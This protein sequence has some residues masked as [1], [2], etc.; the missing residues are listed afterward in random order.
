MTDASLLNVGVNEK[1]EEQLAPQNADDQFEEALLRSI[2][3]NDLFA[4]VANQQKNGSNTS[5]RPWR[6]PGLPGLPTMK[7]KL[8]EYRQMS[9]IDKLTTALKP[10]VGFDKIPIPAIK[11]GKLHG[12]TKELS[13][14]SEHIPKSMGH[15]IPDASDDEDA[16]GN[17]VEH[18]GEED[19]L[20]GEGQKGHKE[21]DLDDISD[22][23]LLQMP[24]DELAVLLAERDNVILTSGHQDEQKYLIEAKD[25][26]QRIEAKKNSTIST[27]YEAELEHLKQQLESTKQ[28]TEQIKTEKQAADDEAREAAEEVVR[29]HTLS[30]EAAAAKQQFGSPSKGKVKPPSTA[31][32]ADAER[33]AHGK[34]LQRIEAYKKLQAINDQE[35]KIRKEMREKEAKKQAE[36]AALQK[37]IEEKKTGVKTAI[38]QRKATEKKQKQAQHKAELKAIK[39]E[40]L[41]A[42]ADIGALEQRIEYA[43]NAKESLEE[44]TEDAAKIEEQIAEAH[45]ASNKD[46]ET[47][48]R[49][50]LLSYKFDMKQIVE[51]KE[52][53]PKLMSELKKLKE[54]E[55]NIDKKRNAELRAQD[56]TN[57]TRDIAGA[58]VPKETS[59][60]FHKFLK[61]TKDKKAATIA[62]QEDTLNGNLYGKNP[63][64]SE[65]KR[66]NDKYVEIL[67]RR[68]KSTKD[69]DKR[70]KLEQ[71]I[72]VV[73]DDPD[74]ETDGRP[75]THND[76][77]KQR[78]YITA[79]PS[80]FTNK[81]ANDYVAKN[82]LS[83][84]EVGDEIIDLLTHGVEK[85]VIDGKN[86]DGSKKY[87]T[88][89]HD[90]GVKGVDSAAV[91][92][93]PDGKFVGV[94]YEPH[95]GKA[96]TGKKI[97]VK[98]YAPFKLPKVSGSGKKGAYNTYT[99]GVQRDED[100]N[101]IADDAGNRVV[102]INKNDVPQLLNHLANVRAG[103]YDEAGNE[104]VADPDYIDR[105]KDATTGKRPDNIAQ[106][107]QKEKDTNAKKI[108]S[109][110]AI[111]QERLAEEKKKAAEKKKPDGEEALDEEKLKLYLSTESSQE[112]AD[113]ERLE[114]ILKQLKQL[115]QERIE[116]REKDEGAEELSKTEESAKL[117]EEY[118]KLFEKYHESK[119]N[120]TKAIDADLKKYDQSNPDLSEQFESIMKTKPKTI[121]GFF[122]ALD[123]IAKVDRRYAN[124]IRESTTASGRLHEITFPYYF[125][126]VSDTNDLPA[127]SKGSKGS[128]N[129][130]GSK[131]SKQF[132][133]SNK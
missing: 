113:R 112:K 42:G 108:S 72:Q 107:K 4:K 9:G 74:Y 44:L 6:L 25:A 121:Q 66:A 70:S 41:Q 88:I 52:K 79:D 20:E 131:D 31:K 103:N 50:K 119:Q 117:L 10:I 57:A 1:N 133:N 122:Q 67:E 24:D 77:E 58:P 76:T 29:L 92:I 78:K 32:I 104:K 49:K 43:L 37:S 65:T 22:E 18:E 99:L 19:D 128:K 62:A 26:K 98:G 38:K 130:K 75:E 109:L 68:L 105:S 71:L 11:P 61:L 12:I 124:L 123:E 30:K 56:Q 15:P 101:E 3:M 93:A 96:I 17:V 45:S 118:R 53:I 27:T 35:A 80:N 91:L 115:K 39:A 34:E 84:V 55:A 13:G 132:R 40:K 69:P 129:N 90:R 21:G 7:T 64:E 97:G 63:L 120:L 102:I 83:K 46:A 36:E 82:D 54:R 85:I 51:D 2:N 94:A 23:A 16:E 126:V 14:L 59:E 5:A 127:A 89:D 47:S 60:F 100:G 125:N 106:R 8:Q 73:K 114:Q 33:I 116:H 86:P 81:E 87:K 110:N 95:K 28:E 111:E 48:L